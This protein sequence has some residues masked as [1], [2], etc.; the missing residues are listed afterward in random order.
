MFLYI[1]VTNQH[2]HH[3]IT[4]H[5]W[6]ASVFYL[7]IAIFR[8]PNSLLYTL[9]SIIIFWASSIYTL[10]HLILCTAFDCYLHTTRRRRTDIY[11]K[12]YYIFM[13]YI[14][15]VGV[16]STILY[17]LHIPMLNIYSTHYTH[18]RSKIFRAKTHL[19]PCI[20]SSEPPN[21]IHKI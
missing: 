12:Y 14:Y 7:C 1:Y 2:H 10:N 9:T 8:A 3:H 18:M 15:G 20:Y 11:I 5:Q 19:I 4:Q 6:Q 17:V 13:R 21:I 16:G